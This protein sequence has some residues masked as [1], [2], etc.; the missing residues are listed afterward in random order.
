MVPEAKRNGLLGPFFR[1]WVA[2]HDPTTPKGAGFFRFPRRLS[3]HYSTAQ[4]ST[5]RATWTLVP[6]P[7]PTNFRISDHSI[8]S[9]HLQKKDMANQWIVV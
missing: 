5:S 1:F 3:M 6:T 7:Q 8:L 9:S 4:Q 2:I